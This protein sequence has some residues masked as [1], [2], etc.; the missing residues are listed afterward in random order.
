MSTTLST[1]S[2]SGLRPARLIGSVMFSATS[3][4]GTRLNAWKTKPTRSRRS[5]VSFLS[6]S[7][8]RSVSPIHTEPLVRSS[9]PASVCISVDLPEPDGP[10]MAVN[11]PVAKSTVTP[12]SA[13]TS[14][15]PLPYTL[16]AS[17][18]RAAAGADRLDERR[19]RGWCVEQRGSWRF[20]P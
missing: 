3:S 13:R 8:V 11:W 10:M 6:L 14:A 4:V 7:F 9:S 19:R 1:H 2:R 20:L 5:L 18:A 16:A 17:T 12:S 15:S